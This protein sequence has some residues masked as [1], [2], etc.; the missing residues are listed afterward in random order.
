MRGLG[1]FLSLYTP[2]LGPRGMIISTSGYMGRR[3]FRGL[4]GLQEVISGNKAR[5]QAAA[6]TVA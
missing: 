2:R 3:I 1:A 6:G 4:Q 5:I